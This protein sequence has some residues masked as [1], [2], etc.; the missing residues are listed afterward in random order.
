MTGDPLQNRLAE[1]HNRTL[2]N[3][4]RSMI[5]NTTLQE[6]SWSRALK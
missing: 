5:Y 4:I 3:M 6:Y 2:R 1:R